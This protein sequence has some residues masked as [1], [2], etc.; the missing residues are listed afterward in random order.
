MKILRFIRK[1]YKTFKCVEGHLPGVLEE[2]KDLTGA[3]FRFVNE[4]RV[5]WM[6]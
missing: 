2:L 6:S 4:L 3:T 5:I 1:V